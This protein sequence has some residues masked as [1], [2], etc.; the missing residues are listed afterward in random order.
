LAGAEP[1][2]KYNNF[3]LFLFGSARVQAKA[4]ERIQNKCEQ[5]LATAVSEATHSLSHELKKS[6]RLGSVLQ[7]K[8]NKAEVYRLFPLYIFPNL[9]KLTCA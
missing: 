5:K 4:V 3:F 9:A 2:P 7:S 8:L 1:F 6:D